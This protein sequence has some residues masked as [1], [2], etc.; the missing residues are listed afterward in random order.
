MWC[1]ALHPGRAVLRGRSFHDHED[2]TVCGDCQVFVIMGAGRRRGTGSTPGCGTAGDQ[3]WQTT[4]MT[5]DCPPVAT[6]PETHVIFLCLQSHGKYP[7]SWA[8]AGVILGCTR[9]NTGLG[10]GG[11]GGSAY[12]EDA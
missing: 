10:L 9:G 8:E 5:R 2:F 7:R 4:Q 1:D 3:S 11:L 12:V 6:G